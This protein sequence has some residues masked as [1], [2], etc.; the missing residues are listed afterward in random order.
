[1]VGGLATV[2]VLVLQLTKGIDTTANFDSEEAIAQ[3]S[4]GRGPW[5]IIAWLAGFV[6]AV[7]LVGFFA[8][9]VAF[10]VAFLRFVA[11]APGCRRLLLTGGGCAFILAFANFLNL[12]FPGGLLQAYF[13]LPWPLR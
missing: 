12:V 1:V 4:N 13:D 3:L 6:A 2:A 10:F 7:S 5:G 8:A 11:R 9:L